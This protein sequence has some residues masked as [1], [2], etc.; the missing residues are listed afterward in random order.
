MKIEKFLNP[1][2]FIMLL[3][4]LWLWHRNFELVDEA[5]NIDHENVI[6]KLDNQAFRTEA[7]VLGDSLSIQ[8]ETILSE[9]QARK[10][11]EEEYAELK[12]VKQNTR[13]FTKTEIK[14]VIV[15]ADV[16][17]EL[18][19]I[20]SSTYMKIP[21]SYSDST[22]HYSVRAEVGKLGLQI[23]KFSIPNETSVSVGIRKTSFF[24]K[25]EPVVLVKHSNP[26]VNTTGMTNVTVKYEVPFY[27]TRAFNI[28]V[29][30]I[31]GYL[32]AK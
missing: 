10:V 25:A 13:I 18:A 30:F 31:G 7:S 1:G 17:V 21:A 24:R 15:Q 3:L 4:V 16:P 26:L 22:E 6:L 19:E 32:L 27:N 12:E 28:G 5:S 9:R 20:D 23:N 29:G 11:L 2:S 8:K 14:E